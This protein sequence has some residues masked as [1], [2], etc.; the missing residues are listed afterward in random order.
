MIGA[1]TPHSSIAGK[2][3]SKAA[4]PGSGSGC[5]GQ[6][7]LV[8]A[9]LISNPK[10]KSNARAAPP[11]CNSKASRVVIPSRGRKQPFFCQEKERQEP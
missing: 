8:C 5:L 10:T 9:L 11:Q 2:E 1:V 6:G 3:H 4:R 7:Q